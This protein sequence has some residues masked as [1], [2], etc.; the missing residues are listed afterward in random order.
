[1]GIVGGGLLPLRGQVLSRP[2]PLDV[3]A[4]PDHGSIADEAQWVTL[5]WVERRKVAM[6]QD[7]CVHVAASSCKTNTRA[8]PSSQV[9]DEGCDNCVQRRL[10]AGCST[11]KPS[12]V[13]LHAV[14]A[15]TPTCAFARQTPFA[16]RWGCWINSARMPRVIR[17]KSIVGPPCSR[18]W[19]A[20]APANETGGDSGVRLKWCVGHV[21]VTPS[22]VSTA[23]PRCTPS[24]A[25]KS[26]SRSMRATDAR[27]RHAWGS[28]QVANSWVMP[29]PL[30]QAC[31]GQSLRARVCQLMG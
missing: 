10:N 20:G 2:D 5:T 8:S 30:R 1:M 27:Q 24:K 6:G 25:E 18:A 13:Q 21:S 14:R 22:P 28:G 9:Q 16:L 4:L 23:N 29:P 3:C 31:G 19:H 26:P 15:N 11:L 17:L 12:H 7:L